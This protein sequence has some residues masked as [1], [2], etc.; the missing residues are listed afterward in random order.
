VRNASA[1]LLIKFARLADFPN[2]HQSFN[3]ISSRFERIQI[4]RPHSNGEPAGKVGF[5][6]GR[7]WGAW[8]RV[9]ASASYVQCNIYAFVGKPALAR[10]T[11]HSA[12]LS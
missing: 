2:R 9:A 8:W 11:E 5:W 12:H 3:C 7:F 6:R 10:L 1:C 4:F